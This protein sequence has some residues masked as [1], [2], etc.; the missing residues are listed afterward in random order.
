MG[1]GVADAVGGAVSASVVGGGVGVGAAVGGALGTA[2]AIVV[3]MLICCSTAKF[4]HW[5]SSSAFADAASAPNIRSLPPC[6]TSAFRSVFPNAE[7]TFSIMKAHS[8][9]GLFKTSM[10]QICCSAGV[11]GSSAVLDFIH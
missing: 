10:L 2:G 3:G 5:F 9:I 7:L 1:L 8:T 6:F 11:I 4:S